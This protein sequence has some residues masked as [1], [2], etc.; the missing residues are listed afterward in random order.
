[1]LFG[2]QLNKIDR[3]SEIGSHITEIVNGKQIDGLEKP[4]DEQETTVSRV[5]DKDK[6]TET[7]ES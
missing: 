1:M 6:D 4:A 3:A 2:T 7:S 5:H